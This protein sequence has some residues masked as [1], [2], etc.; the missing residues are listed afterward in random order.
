M[1]RGN[2]LS[3]HGRAFEALDIMLDR[4]SEGTQW[5]WAHILQGAAIG[6]LPDYR[7]TFFLP[8]RDVVSRVC[9]ESLDIILERSEPHIGEKWLEILEHGAANCTGPVELAWTEERRT[10]LLKS[11]A[12]KKKRKSVAKRA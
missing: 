7:Q 3:K 6:L 12:R 8:S 1:R 5:E 11:R 4:Q 9:F 2:P 10:R